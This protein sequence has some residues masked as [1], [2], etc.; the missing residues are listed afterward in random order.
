MGKRAVLC[1]Y[2]GQGNGGDEA[3]LA[4]LLQMLP[5][6]VNPLVLSGDP[7]ATQA[8]YGVEAVDRKSGLALLQALKSAD[9]FIFGGG[10]LMQ[11]ST[12]S[13]SLLYYGGLMGLA[14]QLNLQTIAW[15]QGIGPLG[16]SW[17]RWI[18]RRVFRQCHGVSVRDGG[19]AQL[20]TQWQVPYVEAPDPV[21]ALEAEPMPGLANLPNPRIAVNLRTHP[22]LTPQR[23]ECL[24]QACVDLQRATGACFLLLPFQPHA[25]RGPLSALA[26]RL[27]GQF[28]WL[29]TTN[30]R[31]LKGIFQGVD[32]TIA[33]R[34]HGLIMAAAEGCRCVALSYDPK[35]SRLREDLGLPGYELAELPAS[36]TTISRLWL[37]VY[38]NGEA[39]S[40]DRRHSLRDRALMHQD[41]LKILT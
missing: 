28:H 25:D 1:G 14:Q 23:L 29:E 9:A 13:A 40:G 11:D 38:A 39:L 35:V 36:S 20:L 31:Q 15:A 34:L 37:E 4:T 5:S 19:S 17:N 26:E 10:S 41:V 33:M 24:V 22:S 27:P 12:S 18:T 30:P 8:A 2:Y 7:P 3:L 16:R 6:T 32:M 21:W